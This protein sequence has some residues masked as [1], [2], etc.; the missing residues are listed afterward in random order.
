[1]TGDVDTTQLRLHGP[2]GDTQR[3]VL[4]EQLGAVFTDENSPRG[5]WAW[6]CPDRRV[7]V[8]VDD[9][10]AGATLTVWRVAPDAGTRDDWVQE[11]IDAALRAAGLT[12]GP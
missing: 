2:I 4:H 10:G 11:R 7:T 6:L 1:M 3:A 12:A 8:T 5:Q 9:D